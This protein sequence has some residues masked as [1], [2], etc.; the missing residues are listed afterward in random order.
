MEAGFRDFQHFLMGQMDGPGSLPLRA[1]ATSSQRQGSGRLA[2]AQAPGTG[3]QRLALPGILLPYKGHWDMGYP[4]SSPW[5]SHWA[6]D[7]Q[8]PG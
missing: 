4:V 3:Q 2:A 1:Q 7:E 6:G 5:L 8:Q